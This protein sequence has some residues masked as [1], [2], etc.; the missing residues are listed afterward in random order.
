MASLHSIPG[1]RSLWQ[2][3]LGDPRFCIA[4]LDGP[5]DL[6]HPC[7]AG[8][9]LRRANSH[10]TDGKH[11]IPET[12]EHATHITSLM[13]GQHGSSIEGI[14]P[15]CRGINVPVIY[16]PASMLDPIALT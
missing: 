8:A 4:I 9:D 11:V 15:R 14:A 5:A 2:K 6:M 3:T 16:D 1:I 13:L 7:F 10:W 12:V